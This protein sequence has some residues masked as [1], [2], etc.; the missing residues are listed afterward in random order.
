MDIAVPYICQIRYQR[1]RDDN[2]AVWRQIFRNDVG[3]EG[4]LCFQESTLLPRRKRLHG[5]IV[6]KPCDSD[7]GL[8]IPT[9]FTGLQ[10]F[11]EQFNEPCTV[12]NVP[13]MF[14]DL[15]NHYYFQWRQSGQNL[16]SDKM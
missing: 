2:V 10:W 14:K 12:L 5:D 16:C 8:T 4:L 11:Y 3:F 7:G 1:R 13:T 15:T 6:V 9:M